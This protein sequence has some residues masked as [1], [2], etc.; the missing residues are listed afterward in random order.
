MAQDDRRIHHRYEVTRL[1]ASSNTLLEQAHGGAVIASLLDLVRRHDT[2]IPGDLTLA[3]GR[4][5][6]RF[7]RIGDD[8]GDRLAAIRNAIGLH[9]GET[10]KTISATE[11]EARRL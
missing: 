11:D 7:R 8:Q 2:E 1:A 3:G 10:L 6:C 9:Q 4:F 5:A